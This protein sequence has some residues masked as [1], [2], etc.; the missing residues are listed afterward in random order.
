M[1]MTENDKLF[2]L[3]F[4]LDKRP[5]FNEFFSELDYDLAALRKIETNIKA[6]ISREEDKIKKEQEKQVEK[7]KKM[8]ALLKS[9]K[10]QGLTLD[11]LNKYSDKKAKQVKKTDGSEM[12]ENSLLHKVI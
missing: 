9:L 1:E 4:K 2:D 11:D 3:A 8:Q 7:Q 10:A 12:I 6:Y 5:A